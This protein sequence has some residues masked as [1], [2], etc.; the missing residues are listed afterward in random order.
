MTQI[1]LD[2]N[3]LAQNC[4]PNELRTNSE[5]D[6]IVSNSSDLRIKVEENYYFNVYK[7]KYFEI[8]HF[9]INSC[10]FSVI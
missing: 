5:L 1:N 8:F 3:R 6:S 7:V 4:L 10:I 2:L 9:Y